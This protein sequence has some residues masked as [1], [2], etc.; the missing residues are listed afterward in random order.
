LGSASSA[1]IELRTGRIVSDNV[2]LKAA[3]SFQ[4]GTLSWVTK[5]SAAKPISENKQN[6]FRRNISK[7]LGSRKAIE[8]MRQIN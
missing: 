8:V 6:N 4:A 7:P 1:M 2:T 3:S 5:R